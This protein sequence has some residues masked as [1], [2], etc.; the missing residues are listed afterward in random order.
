M[1]SASHPWEWDAWGPA[2]RALI[3]E[4]HE[5]GIA[6][7]Q[8]GVSHRPKRVY[9]WEVRQAI[10]EAADGASWPMPDSEPAA[11]APFWMR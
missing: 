11:R 5:L 7:L 9:R 6:P 10:D 8:V 2:S 1:R 4:L 3:A